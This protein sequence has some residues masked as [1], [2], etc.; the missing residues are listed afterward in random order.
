MQMVVKKIPFILNYA[1]LFPGAW[2]A[3]RGAPSREGGGG[4][5]GG[6]EGEL[7][8]GVGGGSYIEC[9]LLSLLLWGW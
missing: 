3:T 6:W 8:C 1:A 9:F 2:R 4:G 5:G 7:V